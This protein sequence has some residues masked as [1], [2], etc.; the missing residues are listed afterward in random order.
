MGITAYVGFNLDRL[1]C[2]IL[3][4]LCMEILKIL[5]GTEMDGLDNE[6]SELAACVM[7]PH[8]LS[9]VFL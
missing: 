4:F 6:F 2:G 9:F 8:Q 1:W 3:Q 5:N 7:G